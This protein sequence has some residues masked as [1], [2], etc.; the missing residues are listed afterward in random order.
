MSHSTG[1]FTEKHI[2]VL[3]S[4][5]W[6]LLIGNATNIEVSTTSASTSWQIL[7]RVWNSTHMNTIFT[8]SREIG[9]QFQ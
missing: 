7:H 9:K 2:L 8:T 4:T 5:K 6:D 1:I 3:T